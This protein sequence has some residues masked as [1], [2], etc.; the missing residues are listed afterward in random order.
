MFQTGSVDGGKTWSAMKPTGVLGSPPHLV[1]HSSG[2]L[3]CVYGYRAPGFG[4]RV[5]LSK[6]DGA[7]WENWIIRDD[8]PHSDL[9]YP[10]SVELS[11]GNIYTIY[12]QA[13][14]KDEKCS[15]MWS[16]WRLPSL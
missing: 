7:T 10:A 6:D 14:S 9:G 11:D 13:A 3:V 15:L 5:L 16:R 8:A 12:Y 1:R 2:V 4:Q